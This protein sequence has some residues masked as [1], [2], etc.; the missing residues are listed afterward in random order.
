LSRL[1]KDEQIWFNNDTKL[2]KTAATLLTIMEKG[3]LEIFL[4][5]TTT[6]TTKFPYIKLG[7]LSSPHNTN[8]TADNW[9]HQATEIRKHN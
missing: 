1:W 5:H 3:A 6:Q 2:T 7:H 9:P 4:C 8:S